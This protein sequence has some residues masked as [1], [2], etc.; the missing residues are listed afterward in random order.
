MFISAGL[1][2]WG[3]KCWVCCLISVLMETSARLHW[4]LAVRLR[5]TLTTARS[6]LQWSSAFTHKHL[7]TRWWSTLHTFLWLFEHYCCFLNYFM[8][9]F[10]SNV[11]HSTV[12]Y[13]AVKEQHSGFIGQSQPMKWAVY[14]HQ[15]P[16]GEWSSYISSEDFLSKTQRRWHG[17]TL[18]LLS[19]TPRASSSFILPMQSIWCALE[20]L[21]PFCNW[22][23]W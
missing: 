6:A 8:R 16:E 7:Y 1:S 5:N 13:T 10:L 14:A 3:S 22:E 20:R 21:F 9:I 4:H 23:H 15:Q 11:I 17:H 19:A 18:F 2:K 12:L